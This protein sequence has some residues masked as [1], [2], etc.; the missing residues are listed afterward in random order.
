MLRGL[1]DLARRNHILLWLCAVVAI[2]Q[3][4]FGIIVPVVPLFAD[5]FG[6]MDLD[7]AR[8]KAWCFVHAMLDACWDYEDGTPWQRAVAYVEETLSF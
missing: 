3:L 1:G 5:S 7:Q 4:G 6:V 2:N 8:A